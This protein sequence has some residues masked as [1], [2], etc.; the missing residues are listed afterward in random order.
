MYT[1]CHKSCGSLYLDQAR[2][3]VI[4]VVLVV[5]KVNMDAMQFD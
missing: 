4:S 5:F 2:M 1:R 3:V